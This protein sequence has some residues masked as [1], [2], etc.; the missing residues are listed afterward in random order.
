VSRGV[1]SLLVLLGRRPQ[2]EPAFLRFPLEIIHTQ[3]QELGGARQ[4]ETAG[5]QLL[6]GIV[7]GRGVQPLPQGGGLVGALL[8]AAQFG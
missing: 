2:R 8:L 1:P 6:E 5:G 7:L 4:R 3:L